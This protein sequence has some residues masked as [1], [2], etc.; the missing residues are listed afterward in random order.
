M[1]YD[2]TRYDKKRFT[3]D[4]LKDVINHYKKLNIIFVDDEENLIFL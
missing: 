4:N 3:I 2:I 1:K